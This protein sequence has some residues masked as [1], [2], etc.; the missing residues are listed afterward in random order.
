MGSSTRLMVVLLLLL[1]AAGVIVVYFGRRRRRATGLLRSCAQWVLDR[2]LP[3]DDGQAALT[4]GPTLAATLA[5]FPQ[6]KWN[7]MQNMLHW[8]QE[9][10]R[11]DT[12][13]SE[14]NPPPPP[15]HPDSDSPEP[16]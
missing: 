5:L 3:P 13:I 10:S 6:Q 8:K 1:L 12:L 16:A 4:P 15:P 14:T 11:L 7:T 9:M 2:R